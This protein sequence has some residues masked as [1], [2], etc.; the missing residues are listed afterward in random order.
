MSKSQS[1]KPRDDHRI[2]KMAAFLGLTTDELSSSQWSEVMDENDD[3]FVFG[4]ILTFDASTPA[5][6]LDKLPNLQPDR[7]V[8]IPIWVLEGEE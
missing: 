5:G 1:D 4:L 3:G 7:S 2:E 8:N 6:I